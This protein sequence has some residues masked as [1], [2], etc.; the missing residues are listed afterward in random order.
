VIKE[1]LDKNE[2]SGPKRLFLRIMVPLKLVGCWLMVLAKSALG[3]VLGR[4]GDWA[5]TRDGLR[6]AAEETAKIPTAPNSRA[7]AGF[8]AFNKKRFM[9]LRVSIT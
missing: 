6:Y 5:L 9:D 2:E 3:D 7:L 1:E 8:G 4:E